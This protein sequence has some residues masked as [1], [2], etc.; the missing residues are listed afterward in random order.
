MKQAARHV[1]NDAGS[2]Q[3]G[4]TI[5]HRDLVA[6]EARDTAGGATVCGKNRGGCC[7]RLWGV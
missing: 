2:N 1:G 4:G 5:I 6:N 7:D 3:A